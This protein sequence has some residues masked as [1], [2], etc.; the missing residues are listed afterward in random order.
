VGVVDEESETATLGPLYQRRG[1]SPQ[2]VGPIVDAAG[3]AVVGGGQQRSES[4]ERQ[5]GSGPRGGDPSRGHPGRFGQSQGF[6]GQAAL[7]HAGRPGDHHPGGGTAGNQIMEPVQLRGAPNQRPIFARLSPHCHS[8][9][10][11][12]TN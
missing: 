1:R 11:A 12:P 8:L 6:E 3:L 5:G 7:P 4:P 9:A 2:Q 10:Q